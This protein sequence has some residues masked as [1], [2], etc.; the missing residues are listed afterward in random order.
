[1]NAFDPLQVV[2]HRFPLRDYAEA[3]ELAARGEAGKVLL[4]PEK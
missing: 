3:I 1:M 2:T 4:Y